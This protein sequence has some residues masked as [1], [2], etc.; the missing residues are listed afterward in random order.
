MQKIQS[1][2]YP[3]RVILIADLAGFTVENTIVYA[4]TVKM[5]VGVDNVIQFDIQNADQKRIDLVNNPLIN[6]ISMNVMDMSGNALANSPYTVTPYSSITGSATN[7]TLAGTNG[8]GTSSTLSIPTA[9]ITGSFVVGSVIT[10][11]TIVGTVTVTNVTSD[12]DSA[13]TNL[14]VSFANQTVTNAAHLSITGAAQPL[15]GIGIVT[16]PE[17]DLD[18]LEDQNLQY[19]VTGIDT[20]GNEIMLYADS[21]FGAVGTIQVIGNAMPKVRDEV[22]Y[23]EFVG[24]INFMGNVTNHTSAIPCKFYE[25]EATQYMNFDVYLNNFIGT[26]Y[27][28]ATEDMSIAVSSFINAPRLQSFTCTTPTTT[29]ISFTNVPVTSTGGQYNY[30][31]VSWLYPDIWQYGSQDPTSQYGLVT[32][33]VVSS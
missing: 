18:E 27:V 20:N 11:S 15:K 7:V 33:V 1:Y 8:Q 28:E 22:I 19:S 2:L 16:I 31:R 5:Y 3:N 29:T 32:K 21:R 9:N 23:D 10:G 24:E 6:N 25:A 4:K 13:T 30:M 14:T 26:V 12:V 17:A